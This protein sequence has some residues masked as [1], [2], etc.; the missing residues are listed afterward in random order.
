MLLNFSF[1]SVELRCTNNFLSQPLLCVKCL[2]YQLDFSVFP[3]GMN[4]EFKHMREERHSFNLIHSFSSLVFYCLSKCFIRE[5][6][7]FIK[8]CMAKWKWRCHEQCWESI[9]SHHL[10]TLWS[11]ASW[12]GR[13]NVILAHTN[14]H[15]KNNPK[16]HHNAVNNHD[17]LCRLLEMLHY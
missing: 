7:V 10:N 15:Q 6:T 1:F 3:Y 4:W 13:N 5:N 17:E 8:G 14:K 12:H 9:T 16:F 11:H 2:I